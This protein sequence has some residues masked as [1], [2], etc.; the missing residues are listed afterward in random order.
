MGKSRV[1]ISYNQTNDTWDDD[2]CMNNE[3]RTIYLSMYKLVELS[4]N[5]LS[6]NVDF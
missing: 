2:T 6:E 4:I 1:K 5:H 3:Q